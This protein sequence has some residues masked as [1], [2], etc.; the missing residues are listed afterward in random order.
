MFKF[1]DKVEILLCFTMFLIFSIKSTSSEVYTSRI[2][3]G[4]CA[5]IGYFAVGMLLRKINFKAKKIKYC[6]YLFLGGTA[7]IFLL[8]YYV[9][10]SHSILWNIGRIVTVGCIAFL[11]LNIPMI[12]IK[13][14]FS[15]WL[16]NAS[17]VIY[18]TYLVFLYLFDKYI[19][20]GNFEMT[21]LII[22]VEISLALLLYNSLSE[23][24]G[25]FQI[26]L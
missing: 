19:D 15:L 26:L 17:E 3:Y 23:K 9:V 18:L 11:S 21:C 20:L 25:I 24:R 5:G 16:R 14:R 2:M 4:N 6:H 8:T 13:R 7:S 1:R 22:F 10:E 12:K